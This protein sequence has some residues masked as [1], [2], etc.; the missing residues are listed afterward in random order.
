MASMWMI[1]GRLGSR[2]VDLVALL[3][4]SRLLQPADFGLLAIAMSLIV[5]GEAVLDLP[6]L[7]PA[8]ELGIG[9]AEARYR[10]HPPHPAWV[11]AGGAGERACL[12]NGSDLRQDAR[13]LPLVLVLA[14]APMI[15][16]VQN[17]RP[18]SIAQHE[19]R[20]G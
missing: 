11:P 1:L 12:A 15:R 7:T 8:G 19:A 16:G 4:L 9:S 3:L 18:F 2:L 20:A 6:V 14:L 10:L 17:R 13:V 5:I